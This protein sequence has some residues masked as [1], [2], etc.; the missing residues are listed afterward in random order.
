MALDLFQAIP[1]P[2]SGFRMELELFFSPGL[3]VAQGSVPAR[4]QAYICLIDVHSPFGYSVGLRGPN[5][6]FQQSQTI[7][8]R[9]WET[10]LIMFQTFC[11]LF[12]GFRMELVLFS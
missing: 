5:P 4:S 8:T 1:R 10:G 11:K 12:P 2:I 7:H 6:N 3:W 9:A